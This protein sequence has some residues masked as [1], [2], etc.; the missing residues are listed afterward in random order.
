LKNLR[1]AHEKSPA[2]FHLTESW[3]NKLTAQGDDALNLFL[4]EFQDTDR[5]QRRQLIGKAQ[6]DQSP[7]RNTSG[8]CA[9]FKYLRKMLK[10]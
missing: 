7:D 5:Q 2:Q 3:P 4:I 6:Q 8:E 10:E 9:L 1:L